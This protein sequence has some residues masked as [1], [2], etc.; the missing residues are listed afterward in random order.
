MKSIY[1]RNFMAVALMVLVCFLI[2]ISSFFSICRN[3]IVSEYRVDME[4]SARE[5]ARVA[6]AMG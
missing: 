6:N 4:N 3:Y 2:L 1:L 5:L